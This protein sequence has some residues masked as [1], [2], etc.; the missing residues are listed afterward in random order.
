MNK[1]E[2]MAFK[3]V[4]GP[5]LLPLFQATK[6]FSSLRHKLV[7]PKGRRFLTEVCSGT[8]TL[9]IRCN[10]SP[11]VTRVVCPDRDVNL[12]ARVSEFIGFGMT[13]PQPGLP[14]EACFWPVEE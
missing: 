1:T 5:L 9:F 7:I 13:T 6:R 8:K 11:Y 2:F 4:A 12:L 3:P 14:K 10:E